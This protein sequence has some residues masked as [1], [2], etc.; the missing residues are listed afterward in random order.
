MDTKKLEA[1]SAAVLQGSFTRAAET[2]GYTQSGLTHMMNALEKELGFPVLIRDRSGVRLTP[3]GERIFP[4]V[5]ECL[6]AAEALEREAALMCSGREETLR[7]AAYASVAV[8]WLP[9]V[10]QQ[11]RSDHPD[12]SVHL[13]MGNVEEVFR[14]LRQGKVDMCFASRQEEPDV[15]WFHL[16]DDPLLVI[17]PPDYE[18]PDGEGIRAEWFDGREMLAPSPGLYLDTMRVLK[19]RGVEPVVRQSRLS[20]S[21]I[22]S[23]VEH[24]LGISVLSEL[25]LRGRKSDV[26]AVPMVPAAYREL[27]VAVLPR[28]ELRPMVR[29]FIARSR[30]II[31]ELS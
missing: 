6:N 18:L 30:E 16:R 14:W 15:T 5:Q 9:E 13:Q 28:R 17:L 2:L 20:D 19:A 10:V 4:L 7:V 1:L 8:H 22:I 24:G 25:V 23:M 12:V 27:G 26:L 3:E 29:R 31:E 21:A 11:F